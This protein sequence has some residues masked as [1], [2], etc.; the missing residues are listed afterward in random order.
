MNHRA[1]KML[2][3]L[4]LVAGS[5]AWL[6]Q[7]A[8]EARADLFAYSKP[9]IAQ[10]QCPPGDRLDWRRTKTLE[11]RDY[12]WKVMPPHI[13]A[14][15]CGQWPICADPETKRIF[16]SVPEWMVPRWLADHELCHL[17]GWDHEV[18]QYVK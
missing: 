5:A 13:V 4:L 11:P 12:E 10:I 17:K 2:A 15:L 7:C 1:R 8:T 18:T 3:S 6:K 9:E 16:A 14:A